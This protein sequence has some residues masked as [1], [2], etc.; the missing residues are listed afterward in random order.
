MIA[1]KIEQNLHSFAAAPRKG[2]GEL[3]SWTKRSITSIGRT[4]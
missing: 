2:I 1:E 3:T 4:S